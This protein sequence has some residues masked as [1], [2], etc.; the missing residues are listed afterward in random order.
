VSPTWVARAAL[1]L[2]RHPDLWT[3]AVRQVLVLAVAGWWRRPPFLPVPDPAYLRFRFQTMY[4][5]PDRAPEP[6]DVITYLRW[7]R[8]WPR[9]TA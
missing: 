6:D 8:A 9:V 4:G 2:A 3:T 5:D 1:A 7:C